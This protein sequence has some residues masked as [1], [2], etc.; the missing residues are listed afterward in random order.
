MFSHPG[1]RAV[2]PGPEVH[3]CSSVI[4]TSCVDKLCAV[5][6]CKWH[7]GIAMQSRRGKALTSAQVGSGL[8]LLISAPLPHSRSLIFMR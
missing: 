7:H 2:I 3:G 6:K 8:L 5:Q 1:S 4:S